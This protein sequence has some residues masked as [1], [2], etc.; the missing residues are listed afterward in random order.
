[1][2]YATHDDK[3]AAP[4]ISLSDLTAL[5]IQLHHEHGVKAVVVSFCLIWCDIDTKQ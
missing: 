3:S 5:E 2:A 4:L 1:M